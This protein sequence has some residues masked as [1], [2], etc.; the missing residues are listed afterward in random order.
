MPSAAAR[1]ASGVAPA[2]RSASQSTH[3]ASIVRA[4]D[5]Y[6]SAPVAASPMTSMNTANTRSASAVVSTGQAERISAAGDRRRS[7]NAA[8]SSPWSDVD[9]ATAAAP[10]RSA[11][12][13][14]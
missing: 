14:R 3:A 8:A 10:T 9:S 2:V 4:S 13:G 6:G 1:R 11:F 5:V 7:P 12:V